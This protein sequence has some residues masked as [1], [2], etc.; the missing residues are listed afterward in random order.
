MSRITR[1]EVIEEALFE[2]HSKGAIDIAKDILREDLSYELGEDI[3]DKLT[4]LITWFNEGERIEHEPR[5][6]P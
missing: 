6:I 5:E 2:L 4:E 3:I 1:R